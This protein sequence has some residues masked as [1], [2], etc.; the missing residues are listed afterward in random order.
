MQL[1]DGTPNESTNALDS[2]GRPFP[3]IKVVTEL[4][5]FVKCEAMQELSNAVPNQM[6]VDK[7]RNPHPVAWGCMLC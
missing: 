1:L 2:Y 5:R 6:T 3:L 7:V 4:L